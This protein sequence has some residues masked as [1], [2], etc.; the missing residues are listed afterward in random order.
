[1]AAWVAMLAVAEVVAVAEEA[2]NMEVVVKGVEVMEV[3]VT[4]VEVLVP[5]RYE[6]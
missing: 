2:V 6:Q 1:M 5:P 3:V 4:G